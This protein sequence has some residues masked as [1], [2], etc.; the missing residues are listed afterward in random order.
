MSENQ[1][2]DTWSSL[3]ISQVQDIEK[4]RANFDPAFDVTN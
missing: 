3:Q 2:L 4:G 1:A